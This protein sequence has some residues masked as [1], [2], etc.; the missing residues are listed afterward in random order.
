MTDTIIFQPSL[1]GLFY[2]LYLFAGSKL[3]A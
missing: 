3:P 2:I 1:T